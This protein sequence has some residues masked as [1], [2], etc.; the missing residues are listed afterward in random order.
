MGESLTAE[1][2]LPLTF[3]STRYA[4]SSENKP[5]RRNEISKRLIQNER[6]TVATT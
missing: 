4:K 3:F 2:Y 6:L 5:A 1:K